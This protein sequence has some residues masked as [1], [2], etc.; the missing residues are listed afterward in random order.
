MTTA[1]NPPEPAR[2]RRRFRALL[3]VALAVLLAGGLWWGW[4]WYTRPMPPEVPLEGADPEV[5]AVIRRAQDDVRRQPRSADAWGR[6]GMTLMANRFGEESVVPFAHA[7]A[8]D[9]TDPRWPY[10]R[11]M[12]LRGSNPDDAL[13]CLRRAV[14]L[15]RADELLAAAHLRLAEE[16]AANG[17]PEEAEV[18]FREVPAGPLSPC[19][20]YGLGAVAAA[21][22][23]LAEA[24]RLLTRC[25]DSPLTRQKASA[26]LAALS[27]RR[28]EKTDDRRRGQLEPDPPWPDP[29]LSECLPLV[30][31]KESRMKLV[32]TLEAQ[33][34]ADQAV[35]LLRALAV[36]YPD[37]DVFLALGI[38]LGRRGRHLES[39]EALR[40]CLAKE[41]QLV[42]AH[43]YLSLALF[44]QA[45]AL[46]RDKGAGRARVRF[47][48]AARSA[49]RA[50]ELAPHNGE[51]HFQLGLTLWCLKR[52]AESI[53]AFRQAVATRPEL[54]DA[55]LWLGKTLAEDGKKDEALSHLRDAERYAAPSDERP[56]RAIEAVLAGKKP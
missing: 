55:H 23:D 36:E 22:G 4:R 35:E 24:E 16:L 25:A 39:E 34:R 30:A 3:A 19:A 50:I 2:P 7:E 9:R 52:R 10:L 1:P 26:Q 14:A 38:V 46:E 44:A 15:C 21:R 12:A 18:H 17:H 40:Q 51:A 37:A 42:R 43:Y 41:P 11:G 56:R 31:G 53:A 54:T 20:D 13:P 6:L 28:G 45:E 33:G 8:F 27:R 49:Q 48:E 47:E 32:N 5:A 29:F